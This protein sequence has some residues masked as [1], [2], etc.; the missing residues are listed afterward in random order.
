MD[1]LQHQKS[2][3]QFRQ[4]HYQEKPLILP[5]IWE[6]MG[7]LLLEDIGY[8]AVAT[9]SYAVA[10]MNGMHDGE[11]I[12]LVT[13]LQ[14]IKNITDRVNVPVSVDF[15]KGFA[16]ND[17]QLIA[18]IQQ[19]IKI[20]VVG[21]NFE[22]TDKKTGKLIPVA[23][24]CAKIEKIKNAAQEMG[25]QLFVNARID[26]FI[27]ADNFTADEK[28]EISCERGKA[29]QAA[30][31]DCIF[32]IFMSEPEAIQQLVESLEVPVNINVSHDTPS[33]EEMEM[34]GVKRIS[35]ASSFQKIAL[36]KMRDFALGLQ[37]Y[38]GINEI[39]EN[40]VTADYLNNLLDKK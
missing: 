29:Y 22:D 39:L 2:T 21:I 37:N 23:K 14:Q 17:E 36:Q 40:D 12:E 16:E 6:P 30:G 15:E 4:L 32:P 19:L 27:S 7:A 35:L 26:A 3:E 34:L 31:A 10:F 1:I 11:N 18:N 9:S 25:T 13:L 33:L 28:Q 38:K 24:Q 20:G 5:N 8:P